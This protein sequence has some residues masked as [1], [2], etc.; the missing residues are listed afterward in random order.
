[1]SEGRLDR[2]M[3]DVAEPLQPAVLVLPDNNRDPELTAVLR[4]AQAQYFARR[5]R[6]TI[7]D[8]GGVDHD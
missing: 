8:R 6:Q 2:A 5:Q 4:D 1:M 3:Q 7:P